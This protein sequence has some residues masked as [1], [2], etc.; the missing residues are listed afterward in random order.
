MAGRPPF[1]FK[2]ALAL[3]SRRRGN[4]L[5]NGEYMADKLNW[6]EEKV[7]V[8]DA[9]LQVVKGGS[10]KPLLVF[11]GELGDPGRLSWDST[12]AAAS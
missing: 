5:K 4:S 6:K 7:R 1:P 3:Y 10:G 8:G 11:H 2:Q 12:L 9:E